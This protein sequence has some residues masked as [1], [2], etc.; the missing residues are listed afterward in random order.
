MLHLFDN[1]IVI[2]IFL[3]I[4]Y[5]ELRLIQKKVRELIKKQSFITK[6]DSTLN[7]KDFTE[8][9]FYLTPETQ[10]RIYLAQIVALSDWKGKEEYVDYYNLIINPKKKHITIASD[11][12]ELFE[13]KTKK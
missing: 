2:N 4:H 3:H 12:P 6:L 8:L 1:H 13:L 5:P 7:A 9:H 11:I 10:K